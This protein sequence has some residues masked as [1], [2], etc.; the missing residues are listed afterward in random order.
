MVAPR[1]PARAGL[2]ARIRARAI[3]TALVMFTRA[4]SAADPAGRS[5]PPRPT[6]AA[7]WPVR[8]CISWRALAAS[9]DPPVSFCSGLGPC[10]GLARGVPGGGRAGRVVHAG[11]GVGVLDAHLTLQAVGVAEKDTEEGA[12]VGDEVIAGAAGDQPVPDLVEGA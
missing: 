12:E 6:A 7:S 2:W 3:L 4:R 11:H 1:W 10:G 8:N 5:R 9:Y